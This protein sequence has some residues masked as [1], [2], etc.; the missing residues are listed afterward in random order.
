MSLLSLR[1]KQKKLFVFF[2]EPKEATLFFSNDILDCLPPLEYIPRDFKICQ[3][4]LELFL[5]FATFASKE[6]FF[7]L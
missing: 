4:F 3:I 2:F 6:S 1:K 5:F 7:S